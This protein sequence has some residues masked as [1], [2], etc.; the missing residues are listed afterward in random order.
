MLVNGLGGT[1]LMELYILNM[2]VHK[3]LEEKNIRAYKTYCG[4]LYD[5]TGY[6]WLFFNPYE[7]G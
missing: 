3:L 2:E 4:Q 5:C 7:A 6:D 1:P